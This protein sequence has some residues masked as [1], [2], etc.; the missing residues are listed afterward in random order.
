MT[1][2][3]VEQAIRN[4][5]TNQPMVSSGP[6]GDVVNNILSIINSYRNFRF[7]LQNH[8]AQDTFK[9]NAMN[10]AQRTE[11]ELANAVVQ[12]LQER[13]IN[14]MMYM[15]APQPQFGVNPPNYNNYIL[16]SLFFHINPGLS[17][18]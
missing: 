3:E 10:I 6:T 17:Q 14:L 11:G 12:T 15:P 18:H 7:L 2:N 5:I 16:T 4:L 13:G 9:F 1:L 8:P